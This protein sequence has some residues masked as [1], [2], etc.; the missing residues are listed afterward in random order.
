MDD[1]EKLLSREQVWIDFFRPVYNVAKFAG[2]PTRGLKF[3][4]E[5][6]AKMSAAGKGR[7]RPPMSEEWKARIS[8]GKIGKKMSPENL[9]KWRENIRNRFTPEY[10]EKWSA[11]RIGKISSEDTRKKL[12]LAGIGNTRAKGFKYPPEAY[13]S[14]RKINRQRRVS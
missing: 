10:R 14:R 12:S 8:S 2:A 3:S 6:R 9:A 1:K 5:T 13:D 7:K 11:V 4:E